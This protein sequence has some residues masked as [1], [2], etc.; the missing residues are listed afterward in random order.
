[1]LGQ[2]KE[3]FQVTRLGWR[4]AF[5]VTNLITVFVALNH[6]VGVILSTAGE[7]RGQFISC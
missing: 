5:S 2:E 1:M 3:G 4:F 6:V 7:W